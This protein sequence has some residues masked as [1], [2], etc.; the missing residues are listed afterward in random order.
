MGLRSAAAVCSSPELVSYVSELANSVAE[1]TCS[2]AGKTSPGRGLALSAPEGTCFGSEEVRSTFRKAWPEQE[3][4]SSPSE[5]ANSASEQTNS[6][7][8]QAANGW[9]GIRVFPHLPLARLMTA[10]PA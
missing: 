3:L 4:G 7:A 5:Q 8:G 10:W 2:V 1:W 9:Q 6:I